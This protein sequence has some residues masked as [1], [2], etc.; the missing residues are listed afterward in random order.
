MYARY[1]PTRTLFERGFQKIF[2]MFIRE[3]ANL[4]CIT[5]THTHTFAEE[6]GDVTPADFLAFVT[7]CPVVPPMGC[8]WPLRILFIR[9]KSK[10]LLTASTCRSHLNLPQDFPEFKQIMDYAFSG[11]GQVYLFIYSC[12]SLLLLSISQLNSYSYQLSII[13]CY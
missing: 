11:F 7:G 5:I 10:K 2:W 9:D 6:P 8:P 3:V 4:F 1:K 12:S 13:L